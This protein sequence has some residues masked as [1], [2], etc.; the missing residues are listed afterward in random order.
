VHDGNCPVALRCITKCGIVRHVC[1][2]EGATSTARCL[3]RLL[4]GFIIA[5]EASFAYHP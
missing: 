3:L 4:F 2:R 1:L 5:L